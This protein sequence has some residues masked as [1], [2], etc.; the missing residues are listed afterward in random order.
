MTKMAKRNSL[1]FSLI[2]LTALTA[3]NVFAAQVY[4]TDP[5]HTSL[6]FAV[7]HL[8]VST[9]RGEFT[10]FTGEIQFDQGTLNDFKADV[11]IQAKS[12]NTHDGDR[13]NHLRSPDFFNVADYPTI[14]FKSNKIVAKGQ[15]YEIFGDLTI[16]DVTK[17]IAIPVS[18]AGPV[19]SPF[20]SQVIG[21]SG[22]VTID[23]QDFGISW[24]NTMDQGGLLVGNNVNIVIEI[25]A[26]KK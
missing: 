15:G 19:L 13:D 23:R 6:G 17:Q 5:V 20:G 7:K 26:H 1:V 11:V 2:F 16:R 3:N 9:V 22:Q 25:E 14:T 21:L 12:I 18:I 4:K 8:M 24:N 10:D